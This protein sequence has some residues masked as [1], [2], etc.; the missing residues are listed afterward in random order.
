MFKVVGG[1][2][3]GGRKRMRQAMAMAKGR[4]LRP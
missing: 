1:M 2:S 3:G 4:G